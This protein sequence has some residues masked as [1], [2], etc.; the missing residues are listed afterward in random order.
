MKRRDFLK[1]TGTLGTST[2]LLDNC[3]RP[4]E[5]LIPLLVPEEEF[6]PGVD[7][8]TNTLCQQCSAG[9]G[10][11]VRVMPGESVRVIENQSKRL[12]V[13]QAKKIEG[14]SQH[15]LN[16]GKTCA[17][18]QAGLQVLYN[19]DRIQNPLKLTGR[20]GSGE[21]QTISWEEAMQLLTGQ[22]RALQASG[23]PEKLV[24]LTGERPRG[25]TR[26]LLERFTSAFG[27]QYLIYSEVIPREALR[28]S[29]RSC[30]GF[31]T[32]PIADIEQSQYLIS[33]GAD[34]FGTFLSPVRY[35]L[36][37][38]RFRQG[39]PG[40][41]G[42]FVMAEPRLSMTA[43]SADEWLPIK[44]GT[45]GLL[46][47]ALAHVIVK[48]SIY[49]AQF[50]TG[51]C[52]G[53]SE[54][55][56]LL[57]NYAPAAIAS[58]IGIPEETI[59][60]VAREFAKRR[61]SL[62]IGDSSDPLS[63]AALHALN[64]LVGSYGK[65]GGM[66]MDSL[67]PEASLLP[68]AAKSQP[69]E[70]RSSFQFESFFDLL[71]AAEVLLLHEVNPLYS[72]AA[73]SSLKTSL[74]KVP[75]IASFSSF[76]DET[77][78]MADLV[79]PSHTYL[80]RWNDDVPEPGIGFPVRTLAQPVVKP[81]LNT[82]NPPDVLLEISRNLGGK[83]SEALPWKSFEEL[84][85][86]SFRP[87]QQL[88][89]G[90][91]VEEK[92]EAFW[93]KVKVAGGWWDSQAP[94]SLAFQ[95]PS[96]KFQLP[97]DASQLSRTTPNAETNKDFP[98]LLHLYPSVALSDGR[99]ANQPWLQEMPDP[100][101]TIMWGSWVELNPKTA[102]QLGI[103]EGDEITVETSKGELQLPAYLYP[104][105]RPEVVAIPLGQGHSRY[106]RYAAGRG[107]N[108]LQL[109]PAVKA[110]LL[111][112]GVP[113]SVSRGSRKLA[114]AKFGSEGRAHSQHPVRR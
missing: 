18:G 111:F 32:L 100:M 1:V 76:L 81:C 78:E 62:A 107:V 55:L 92:F 75:F 112:S 98:L 79:L 33:F 65:P 99:G 66:L 35:N 61:P 72:N 96:K 50:V 63:M 16:Q 83:L 77:T 29:Y 5:K 8:W 58:R 12:Q 4:D 10:I 41:R 94:S 25:S 2:L 37:Y 73:S 46:A 57:E 15:P 91:V 85:Q 45:E 11:S 13:L 39:R 17:R 26:T 69:V 9:C 104:G 14:N 6:V 82:R 44:P 40:L 103:L 48:E 74:E 109:A 24:F 89:R 114:L 101:T 84:I 30:T 43:A 71:G 49:D 27:T 70:A 52:T 47:L 3:G 7:S 19:P 36:A 87:L 54:Y 88:K 95:T 60:R 64:A 53:F 67:P 113:V 86:E 34:L 68:L 110:G 102:A 59:F 31:R 28:Q 90:S 22:L 51:F 56:E 38:G 20:R 108:P 42:K 105:L 21:Y 93:D 97:K 106:G 80:E 23:V